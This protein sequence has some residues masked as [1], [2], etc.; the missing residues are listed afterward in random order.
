MDDQQLLAELDEVLRSMPARETLRHALPEN[1]AWFGRASA[2]VHR[3]GGILDATQFDTS[4]R[5]FQSTS[6]ARATKGYFSQMLTTI[7]KLRSDVLLRTSGPMNSSFDMGATFNYFD[8]LR[9]IIETA[10]QEIFFIDPYL[11]AEFVSKFLPHVTD[12]VRIRLLSQK[13]VSALVSAVTEYVA[14]E[15]AQIEVRKSEDI[16]DRYVFIDRVSCYQSG[17]SFKHGPKFAPTTLTQPA[18][19]FDAMLATYERIWNEAT[20]HSLSSVP[21]ERGR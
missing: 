10:K 9:K 11:D 15:K 2:V 13:K 4:L 3:S 6:D 5:L 7:H 18:D 12:D 8:G 17:T 19:A 16:H 1:F 20:P 21:H 14:Q